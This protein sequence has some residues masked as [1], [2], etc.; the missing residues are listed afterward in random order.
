MK[1]HTLISPIS[2]CI[3]AF[4]LVIWSAFGLNGVA[5]AIVFAAFIAFL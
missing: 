5:V 4:L 1:F 3:L 2:L